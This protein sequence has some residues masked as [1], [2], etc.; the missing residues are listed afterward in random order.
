MRI[1]EELH[2]RNAEEF[3]AVEAALDDYRGRTRSG[4]QKALL[5]PS[6]AS[7]SYV[8]WSRGKTHLVFRSVVVVAAVEGFADS[9]E[10][11]AGRF[12]SLLVF[13]LVSSY[14]GQHRTDL[15]VAIRRLILWWWL[16]VTILRMA[17]WWRTLL[18]AIVLGALVTVSALSKFQV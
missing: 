16:L 17:R 7:V 14:S 6:S 9:P 8:E 3:G 5:D 12:L 1:P 15:L 4:L 10:G 13:Q 2:N 18:E 11:V